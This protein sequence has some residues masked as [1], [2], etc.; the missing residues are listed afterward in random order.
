MTNLAS[1]VISMELQVQQF[2]AT[3]VMMLGLV[4]SFDKDN[5][6]EVC[7]FQH[8]NQRIWS[9]A[10]SCNTLVTNCEVIILVIYNKVCI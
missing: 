5:N 2:W 10:T 8:G 4:L 3:T 7:Q 1:H 6:K 9:L